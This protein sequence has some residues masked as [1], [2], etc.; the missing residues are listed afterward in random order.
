M[1]RNPGDRLLYQLSNLPNALIS[2]LYVPDSTPV[3]VT[4]KVKNQTMF[5]AVIINSISVLAA[6]LF[7]AAQVQCDVALM[8]YWEAASGDI[9]H[10]NVYLS[11]D[12]AEYVKVGETPTTPTQSNPYLLPIEVVDGKTYQVRVEAETADGITGPMSEPS[13]P[14]LCELPQSIT[15]TSPNGGEILCGATEQSI[16]WNTSGNRIDH[17]R[18]LYSTDGGKSYSNTIVASTE[19]DGVYEWEPVPSL[20]SATVKVRAIAEDRNN[21]A[22]AD[23]ESN[24]DFTIDTNPPET[25][26]TLSGTLGE[27]DWYTSDVAL[28]LTAVD[29]LSNIKETKYKVNDGDWRTYFSSL[30]LKG[31][32]IYY[33]SEDRAGNLEAEKSV[34]VRIDKTKPETP[35]VIDD[36]EFTVDGSQLHA[37]WTSSDDDSGISEYQYAIGKTPGGNDVVDWT[38]TGINTEVTRTGLNLTRGQVY[39][40]TVKAKNTAGLWSLVGKSDGI[41]HQLPQIEVTPASLG[42]SCLAGRS[43]P[44][45][46]TFGITNPGFVTLNWSVNDD[47]EWLFCT[48]ANGSCTGETDYVTVSVD[49][50]GLTTGTY[51]ATITISALDAVHTP[52]TVT[53]VLNIAVP[54]SI[55]LLA[56]NG[57]EE[58]RGGGLYNVT[59]NT[60]GDDIAH[61]RIL[62]SDDGGSTYPNTVVSITEDDGIY[63]W[64]VPLIDSSAIRIKIVAEDASNNTLVDDESEGFIV[65]ST[66]PLT[67]ASLSGIQGENGW[68]ISD[69]AITL[70]ATDNL[71]DIRETR[72]KVNN[73]NWE[74]YSLPF[75]VADSTVYYYSTDNAGNT[76]A[77]KL[78]HIKTDKTAPRIPTVTDDGDCIADGS[79]LHASWIS[80][81]PE[82][83]IAEYQYAIGTE[84]G[85]SDIVN[86][87]SVGVDN[88]VAKIG[89]SLILGR[90]YYFSVKAKNQAGLWSLA[91][92]SDGITYQL[93]RIGVMPTSLT[94]NVIAGNTGPIKRTLNIT[95]TGCDML[96]WNISDSASWLSCTPASG[97]CRA[98]MDK[99]I[100][101]VDI[102][103]LIPGTYNATIAIDAIAASN[104]PQS[105]SVILNII[106]SKDFFLCNV[107]Q[108]W[109]LIS[110]PMQPSNTDPEV[111][112]SSIAGQYNSVW[113][114]DP[115]TGWSVYAPGAPSDLE[116]MIPGKGYWL[117]MEVSGTLTIQGTVLEQTGISLRGNAWNLVGYSFLESRNAE[118]CMS[119]V[120]SYIN[121]VWEY[122]P[123][124]AVVK[125]WS[126]YAPK[127][128]SDLEVMKPGYGYWVK[129]DQ[130]CEWYVNKIALPA[131]ASLDTEFRGS[132][133]SYDSSR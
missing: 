79:R 112:L 132:Y 128:R 32:T 107:E 111:V 130:N 87:T 67:D 116:E 109:N 74:N 96:N 117:K 34:E 101:S 19:D 114:Y 36:G 60:T 55:T 84:A 57:G 1:G 66:V 2:A 29:N 9:R 50:T 14:V 99:A 31:S 39:Y 93:P 12:G 78:I 119:T 103:G 47:V 105:V 82:S 35:V 90:V 122:G 133:V 3:R 94:L 86:W 104:S 65:D 88:E 26:A 4:W 44:D 48:P 27:N 10:Y 124:D 45:P 102:T 126:I 59:W 30:I 38:P 68:Y 6:L 120:A 77:H 89:L 83:G 121:S 69:V 25:T 110:L 63:E 129:A 23:D 58:I 51:N 92:S 11:I 91:G 73:G 52:Q 33:Y 125:S 97:D 118:E 41:T 49:I 61:I 127:A 42:F 18:L 28:E 54:L 80:S 95:N 5:S 8:A 22:M 85:G 98:E 71:S 123:H 43:N 106:E 53:A 115:D 20:N 108:G 113:A 17:I 40:F 37:L 46:Q 7:L 62:C 16:S 24:M 64:T 13:D 21:N 72:Y 81:D 131:S 100:V 70:S 15:L 56:P 75:A 76:E